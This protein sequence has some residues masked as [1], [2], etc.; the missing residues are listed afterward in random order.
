MAVCHD[1]ICPLTLLSL[2]FSNE[3][4]NG[5]S[6]PSKRI[7]I[8]IPVCLKH[9]LIPHL[10]VSAFG[11]VAMWVPRLRVDKCGASDVRKTKKGQEWEQRARVGA[12]HFSYSPS[13]EAKCVYMPDNHV[14]ECVLP[15]RISVRA[16]AAP[17]DSPGE[18]ENETEDDRAGRQATCTTRFFPAY[19]TE[20]Y[21]M[22]SLFRFK[23]MARKYYKILFGHRIVSC[24]W[25]MEKS[26]NET[27]A[28]E[29]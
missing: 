7:Q 1:I 26:I 9:T 17:A 5:T 19:G 18:T 24:L 20:A 8:C 10:A 28:I 2:S 16:S 23:V 22:L 14:L 6:L 27:N 25:P 13:V 12:L 29:K 3:H 15:P 4:C 11:W 21:F